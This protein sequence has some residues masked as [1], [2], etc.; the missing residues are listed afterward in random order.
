MLDALI[1][2]NIRPPQGLFE[3]SVQQNADLGYQLPFADGRVYKYAKAGAGITVGHLVQAPV[4]DATNDNSMAIQTAVKADDR[5]IKLTVPTG[6]AS[7]AVDAYAGGYIIIEAGT[8]IGLCRKIKGNTVFTTGAAATVTFKL[9]DK[10]GVAVAISG[11]TVGIIANPYNGVITNAGTGKI[12][13]GAPVDVTSAYYFW[14]QV[15]GVGPAVATAASIAVT[16]YVMANGAYVLKRATNLHAP[17]IGQA[18]SAFVASESGL[19]Y[20]MLE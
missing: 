19:I 3:H 10:V 8:E 17:I 13:G 20:Y 18:F 12:L 16:E 1:Q 15:R 6:H 5:E 11:H 4:V 2:G 7:F 9:R 14:L